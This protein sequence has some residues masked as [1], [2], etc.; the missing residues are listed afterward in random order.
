MAPLCIIFPYVVLSIGQ[1]PLNVSTL[2]VLP[3]LTEG[4]PSVWLPLSFPLPTGLPEGLKELGPSLRCPVN[5]GRK[6]AS[7]F[8]GWSL[9]G[10][11]RKKRALG[12]WAV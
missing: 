4:K 9:K 7:D 2:P 12:H 1:T 8:S 10:T 11:A 3:F 6:R 5:L